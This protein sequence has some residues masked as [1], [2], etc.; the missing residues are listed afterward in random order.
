MHDLCIHVFRL[1][2]TLISQIETDDDPMGFGVLTAT[3]YMCPYMGRSRAMLAI[4]NASPKREHWECNP[5]ASIAWPSYSLETPHCNDNTT[6]TYAIAMTRGTSM[7]Q[8]LGLTLSPVQEAHAGLARIRSRHL[9]AQST[10]ALLG[11]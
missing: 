5:N 3:P 10:T 11:Y 1:I 7:L 8:G 2:E 9:I 4:P 6:P